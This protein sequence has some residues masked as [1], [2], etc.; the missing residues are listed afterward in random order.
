MKII[1]THT[2]NELDKR[3]EFGL[4]FVVN[5]QGGLFY[6][7]WVWFYLGKYLGDREIA[8]HPYRIS[9]RDYKVY[10]VGNNS[11]DDH[12]K[13]IYKDRVLFEIKIFF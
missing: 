13:L 12:A 6:Q 2:Y 7:N 9:E 11:A 5:S 1:L 10:K 8:L 4:N 3:D